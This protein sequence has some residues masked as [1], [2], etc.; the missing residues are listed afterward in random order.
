MNIREL[1]RKRIQ[2]GKKLL[3]GLTKALFDKPNR[4]HEK[5]TAVKQIL[6]LRLDAKLGDSVTSTGFLRS[7][8]ESYP[9]AKITVAT[10]GVSAELFSSFDFINVIEVKKGLGNLL[11]GYKKLR[12]NHYDILVNTSHILSPRVVFLTSKLE[13]SRKI[14]FGPS[15]LQSFDEAVHFDENKD[16]IS[17]RYQ[18][19]L[20]LI[21]GVGHCRE[22]SFPLPTDKIIKA[23]EAVNSLNGKKFILIN[24][25]AGARLRNLSKQKTFAIVELLN[26]V[27][28]DYLVVSIGNEGDQRILSEWISEAKKSQWVILSTCKSIFENAYLVSKAEFVIS[29]DTSL[30]HF[31]SAFQTPLICIY[32]QDQGIEKNSLIWAPTS[33]KTKIIYTK[34]LN[35]LGEDDINNFD[36][37]TVDWKI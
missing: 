11:K 37:Q 15:G 35:D 29:P 18:N 34:G 4:S 5:T 24:S 36:E 33:E 30:V 12:E 19:A 13:A 26:K 8:H 32:R 2:K 20:T 10:M 6:V 1:N 17:V 22:Y 14:S 25:F 7:L 28:P 31:A 23:I 21:G 9:Q 16:H 3:M 27:Y